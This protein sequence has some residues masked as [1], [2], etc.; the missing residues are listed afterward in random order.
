MA[1]I[2]SFGGEGDVNI[3]EA[4]DKISWTGGITVA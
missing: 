2:Q 1:K 3:R 4:I